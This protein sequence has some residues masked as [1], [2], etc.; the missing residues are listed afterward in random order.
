VTV[1]VDR[2]DLVGRRREVVVV[3]PNEKEFRVE[4]FRL[5][6]QLRL[7]RWQEN[8]HD[9]EELIALLR[10]AVPDATIDDLNTLSIEE[11]VPRILAAAM[12][13]TLIVEEA[14]KNGLRGAGE[15][16]PASPSPPSSPTT[17]PSTS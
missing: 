10:L 5:E 15:A 9:S 6:G 13:K 17:T 4:K 2:I 16:V 11:D 1:S 14:L 12:G 3:F 7:K 8:P